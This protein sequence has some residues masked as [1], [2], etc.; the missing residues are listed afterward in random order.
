MSDNSP[1]IEPNQIIDEA[2]I[3]AQINNAP[4]QEYRDIDDEAGINQALID[5]EQ[6]LFPHHLKVIK[7]PIIRGIFREIEQARIEIDMLTPEEIRQLS[8]SQ[9]DVEISGFAERVDILT[10]MLYMI[11]LEREEYKVINMANGAEDLARSYSSKCT[12]NEFAQL[13]RW[14][15]ALAIITDEDENGALDQF[16]FTS[17]IFDDTL[18]TQAIKDEIIQEWSDKYEDFDLDSAVEYSQFVISLIT[19]ADK[20]ASKFMTHL[21]YSKKPWDSMTIQDIS[22]TIEKY[23]LF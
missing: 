5:Y 14:L 9:T 6:S 7:N 23:R 4:G 8:Q 12:P 1:E 18:E 20:R 21:A 16:I 13:C 15:D 11:D 19:S 10:H 22:D 17:L 2:W 3:A